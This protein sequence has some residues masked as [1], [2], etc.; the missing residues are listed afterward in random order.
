MGVVWVT[1]L[2]WDQLIVQFVNFLF[3]DLHA[4]CRDLPLQ[5]GPGSE[6]AACWPIDWLG[7][8]VLNLD[9]YTLQHNDPVSM[10]LL[11]TR[12][13][14]II[15]RATVECDNPVFN[16]LKLSQQKPKK[17]TEECTITCIDMIRTI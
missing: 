5:I 7:L 2:D 3:I 11:D 12:Y 13:A 15:L 16:A 17:A 14:N 4:P 9:K 1:N 10:I 8:G 6:S